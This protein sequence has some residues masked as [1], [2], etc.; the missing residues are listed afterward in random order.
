M[1]SYDEHLERP[2]EEHERGRLYAN[3]EPNGPD[4]DDARD[5]LRERH[6]IERAEGTP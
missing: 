5:A 3:E 1:T 4:P 6:Q 2:Y